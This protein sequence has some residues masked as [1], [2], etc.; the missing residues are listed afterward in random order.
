MTSHLLPEAWDDVDRYVRSV[1][2][3]RAS[4]CKSRTD[5]KVFDNVASALKNSSLSSGAKW[6]GWR[7][8]RRTARAGH[9]GERRFKSEV[10]DTIVPQLFASY[11]TLQSKLPQQRTR[12]TTGLLNSVLLHR[13]DLSAM[14]SADSQ[15]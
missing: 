14:T 4:W 7:S 13:R 8:D 6:T 12:A 11:T 10:N 1:V 3:S 15:R 9:G 2:I 5:T